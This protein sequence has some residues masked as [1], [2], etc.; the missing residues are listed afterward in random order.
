MVDIIEF[1]EINR[2]FSGVDYPEESSLAFLT[3][4]LILVLSSGQLNA[5]HKLSLTQAISPLIDNVAQDKNVS[6]VQSTI[7]NLEEET[8][9]QFTSVLADVLVE[10]GFL[11]I[12]SLE[13]EG[14]AVLEQHQLKGLDERLEQAS[15]F[16]EN[17]DF[18]AFSAAFA[19]LYSYIYG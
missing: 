16:L 10:L 17:K 9:N 14:K 11:E 4:A 13:E 7:A 5:N 6:A 1:L 19:D 12:K 3:K 15:A 18:A 8:K 2:L